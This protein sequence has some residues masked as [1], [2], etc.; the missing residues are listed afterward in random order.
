MP[1][2][3]ENILS[4]VSGGI[5]IVDTL[6]GIVNAAKGALSESDQAVLETKLQELAAVSDALFNRVD[7]KLTEA[8]N[9]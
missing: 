9:H 6:V 8:G 5:G 7:A 2:K 1:V 4:L 3:L